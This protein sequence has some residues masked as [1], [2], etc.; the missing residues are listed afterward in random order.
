MGYINVQTTKVEQA[1]LT[2]R[3]LKELCIIYDWSNPVTESTCINHTHE[4]SIDII[5]TN[6]IQSF[7]LSKA[8]ET[9]F[10]D[11]H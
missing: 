8:V 1:K 2:S 11:F 7:M 5:I 9:G 3:L 6:Q 4:S 10:S